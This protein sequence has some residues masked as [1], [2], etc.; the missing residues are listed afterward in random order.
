MK[1]RLVS[2]LL[3]LPLLLGCC[4]CSGRRCEE[5]RVSCIAAQSC[6]LD[7]RDGMTGFALCLQNGGDSCFETELTAMWDGVPFCA[8]DENGRCTEP[9]LRP[10]ETRTVTVYFR[11][12]H[13]S[14]PQEVI[15]CGRRGRFLRADS[16]I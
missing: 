3:M 1:A 16:A 11:G 8:L 2:L 13:S 6:R 14:L 7:E 10:H 5:G 15:I 9:V 4:S 12:S